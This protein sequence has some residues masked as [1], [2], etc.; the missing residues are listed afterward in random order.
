MRGVNL[1]TYS[2]SADKWGEN[3][4]ELHLLFQ[5][6]NELKSVAL[7]A[8]INQ[9]LEVVKAEKKLILKQRLLVRRRK[10]KSEVFCLFQEGRRDLVV[11]IGI[12]T[13]ETRKEILS[14]TTVY[15]SPNAK[16]LVVEPDPEHTTLLFVLDERQNIIT[17]KDATQITGDKF[18]KT[19]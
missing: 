10:D 8:D 12:N 6:T 15:E 19:I 1:L 9:V 17:I 4:Q 7:K 5:F 14:I 3:Y 18:S 11:K 16:L 2:R 13:S